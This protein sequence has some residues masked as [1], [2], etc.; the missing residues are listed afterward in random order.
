MVVWRNSRTVLYFIYL[1]VGAWIS[2]D[3]TAYSS[4]ATVCWLSRR[5]MVIIDGGGDLKQI[6]RRSFG[7]VGYTV[8]YGINHLRPHRFSCEF[9]SKNPSGVGRML[10]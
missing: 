2:E 10:F 7:L 3:V 5:Q 9:C 4:E 8:N 1:R 6:R